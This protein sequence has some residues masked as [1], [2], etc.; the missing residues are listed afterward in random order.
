MLFVVNRWEISLDSPYKGR[1]GTLEVEAPDLAPILCSKL[2]VVEDMGIGCQPLGQ[3]RN[4]E[5]ISRKPE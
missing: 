4:T 5:G 1:K 2:A 3:G